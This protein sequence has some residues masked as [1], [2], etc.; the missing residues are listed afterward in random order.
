[1][2][3]KDEFVRHL[4]SGGA[5]P[6]P[7]DSAMPAIVGGFD[8]FEQ[9]VSTDG[10]PSELARQLL[11]RIFGEGQQE[12]IE[13]VLLAANEAERERLNRLYETG[14]YYWPKTQ[15]RP[16]H[17]VLLK[18]RASASDLLS[19][20][21]RRTIREL[22]LLEDELFRLVGDGLNWFAK[23][24]AR[25]SADMPQGS[26]TDTLFV[27]NVPEGS[28]EEPRDVLAF[29]TVS[30]ETGSF[31]AFVLYESSRDWDPPIAREH[32]ETFFT[33]HVAPLDRGSR[34]QEAF[35]SGEHRKKANRLLAA[36][37]SESL[38]PEALSVA[39][40]ALIHELGASYGRRRGQLSFQPLREDH[41]IAADPDALAS[42]R[43]ENPLNGLVVRDPSSRVLGYVV[44]C[45][46]D[47]AAAEDARNRL[48][49]FNTFDNVLIVYPE[50]GDAV[51]ELWQ[52]SEQLSGRLT[53]AN[54]QFEGI[55][56]VLNLLSRFFIVSQAAVKSPKDLAERLARRARYLR[57]LSLRQLREEDEH[58]HLRKI[59]QAFRDGLISDLDE[60]QFAD[61]FAQTVAN[62]L[63]TGRWAMH[64]DPSATFTVTQALKSI[65]ATNPFLRG[66]FEALDR[67]RQESSGGLYL[68]MIEDI[69]SLLER[70]DVRHV[71]DY[72]PED[73]AAGKDPVIHF[74]ED[75]L[76]EYDA[77]QRVQ[78][79][80]YYTPRPVVRY[81]VRSVHRQLQEVFGLE[82]GLADCASWAEVASRMEG[83]T[84]PPS[85]D[86]NSTFVQ[87]LDPATGTGTF[88]VEVVSV[89]HETM[90]KKWR[91]KGLSDEEVATQWSTYVARQLLPRLHGFELMMAPY[92]IAHM[93]LGLKLHET[94]Y[95][96]AEGARANVFL[97]NTLEPPHDTSGMLGFAVP[98]LAEESAQVSALKSTHP[99]TVVLGNPPY[100]KISSNLTEEVRAI[101]D[102]YRY[103]DGER[104]KERGAL[105]F[106]I[107]L[108][109]DYVKFFRWCQRAVAS[110]AGVVGLI[111]NNGYLSTPTLR[112]MRDSLLDTFSALLLTNLHGQPSREVATEQGESDENV[113]D[114]Q[115]GVAVFIG[116]RARN[117]SSPDGDV[118]YG[119]LTG[120]RARKYASLGSTTA[121]DLCKERLQPKPP[122]YMFVPI[123]TDLRGEFDQGLSLQA[124]FPLNSAGILTARD[125]L[126]IG[127]TREE[128]VQQIESFRSHP[129]SD[130]EA[131][132]AHGV[133]LNKRFDPAAARKTLR[134]IED[135]AEHVIPVS[136]R[137]F[138]KRFLF[139]HES[140]V[141]SRAFPVTSQ[142]LN[143]RNRML[144]ATRQVTRPQFE[145]VFFTD[146]A[147]E[148]KLA[149]HD[150]NCQGFPLVRYVEDSLLGESAVP[151]VSEAARQAWNEPLSAFEDVERLTAFVYAM[152]HSP[153][154]RGRYFAFIR[155]EF[156]KVRLDVPASLRDALI[157]LGLRLMELHLDPQEARL[158]EPL[159]RTAVLEVQRT[160]K[161]DARKSRV[162]LGASS[163]IESLTSEQ[164]EF[165]VGGYQVAQKWLKDRRG[166]VLTPSE[167]AQYESVIAA[168][169]ETLEI[170][171]SIDRVL[172]GAGGLPA[173]FGGPSA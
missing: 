42:G 105:Q 166:R 75:F 23:G 126:V 13:R 169:T 156:P 43:F 12:P 5:T 76:A 139:Y 127:F 137:P 132:R 2:L 111:T 80:V 114:I 17:V 167:F 160:P 37:S 56:R 118:Y 92:A 36:C 18:L 41:F 155:S 86:A 84:V 100:S 70:V 78:R 130:E 9:D 51:V 55:G 153:L 20:S 73:E 35:V 58:G 34:W 15:A 63:L 61:A 164:W 57:S 128:V 134:E 113:F 85:V 97:T 163:W 66:F 144:V 145:H 81:I 123:D 107:N 162:T 60:G 173:A 65:P 69:A 147:I 103:V 67:V 50:A 141:W 165:R 68:W 29:G 151:N 38:D 87:I 25:R 171:R 148:I 8:G 108:Q 64:H 133:K 112:G 10:A 11:I 143:R 96:F 170:S 150:R 142:F 46:K 48:A 102:E 83:L 149:S 24:G 106:E 89:I 6:E 26:H 124:L 74:F 104:I 4:M 157:P 99:F 120:A 40:Q 45:L 159:G 90:T 72:N 32:F 28:S 3:S 62:G 22:G 110:T 136:Y 79:G 135:I 121:R 33:R 54:A 116:S 77:R 158:P 27:V 140:V 109:D 91:G 30:I 21:P 1:M 53:K 49:R 16:F 101:V 146:C 14:A 47:N 131:C 115:Q 93:K 82:D 161:F 95:V 88:L 154:Y 59:Y 98:A 19:R 52:G 7:P 31:E 71:F 119:E 117:G 152:L 122:R 39:V 138:D 129:G 125:N 94:G 44:Y 172:E 168:I